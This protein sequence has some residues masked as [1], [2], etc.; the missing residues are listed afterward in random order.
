MSDKMNYMFCCEHYTIYTVLFYKH[1][2]KV[3]NVIYYPSMN[4]QVRVMSV[5]Y[6]NDKIHFINIF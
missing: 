6:V 3:I 5:I 2:L 1:R 4:D